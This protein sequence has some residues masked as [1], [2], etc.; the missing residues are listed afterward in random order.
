[1]AGVR[2][3]ADES[4][5]ALHRLLL[6]V[7]AALQELRLLNVSHADAARLI[8]G[9]SVLIRGRDAPACSGPAYAICKGNLVAVGQVERGELRPVR[10]FN[11]TADS[12]AG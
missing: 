8:N 11:F 5:A 7:E 10:V 1:L 3:A 4:E 9:Q 2:K 12:T 6:P